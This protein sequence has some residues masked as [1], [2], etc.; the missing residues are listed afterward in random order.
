MDQVYVII[1]LIMVGAVAFAWY[2]IYKRNHPKNKFPT[3]H[4]ASVVSGEEL[5]LNI[6]GGVYGGVLCQSNNPTEEK[7][8]VQVNFTSGK[9]KE[10][11]FSYH[12]AEFKNFGTLNPIPTYP[13]NSLKVKMEVELKDALAQ[14]RFEDAGVLRDAI[15]KLAEVNR[16][17][18]TKK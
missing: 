9:K 4:P 3:R 8:H 17:N 18:Q 7:M 1:G 12:G 13:K 11:V 16:K 15:N 5:V 2:T 14:E 10:E 6:Y